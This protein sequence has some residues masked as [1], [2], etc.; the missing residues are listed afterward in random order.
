MSKVSTRVS[1]TDT[2]NSSFV[3]QAKRYETK[4]V[5]STNVPD[6]TFSPDPLRY[7]VKTK[8]LGSSHIVITTTTSS[9]S[10]ESY[11]KRAN[12]ILRG[13]TSTILVSSDSR[14]KR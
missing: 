5:T 13:E 8:S 1:T 4:Q 11:I 10:R 9:A 14:G 2:R 6:S 7:R 12:E 3:D